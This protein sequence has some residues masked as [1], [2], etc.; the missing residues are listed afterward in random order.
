[1]IYN[2]YFEVTGWFILLGHLPEQ[3]GKKQLNNTR[4]DNGEYHVWFTEEHTILRCQSIFGFCFLLLVCALFLRFSFKSSW[5]SYWRYFY[6]CLHYGD[7]GNNRCSEEQEG[8]TQVRLQTPR[9]RGL[10]L[11]VYFLAHSVSLLAYFIDVPCLTSTDCS[12]KKSS[13]N[14]SRG[15][16]VI[17]LAHQGISFIWAEPRVSCQFPTQRIT[18][19]SQI[20]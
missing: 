11:L 15:S 16:N 9:R 2:V 19:F 13:A 5:R 18:L 1:M 3:Q 14:S 17:H 7:R 20:T 8:H 12:V 4:Y 6:A 10:S